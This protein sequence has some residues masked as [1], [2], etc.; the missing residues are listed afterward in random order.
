[1]SRSLRL[2]D[3]MARWPYPRRINPA[4]EEVSAESAA[5]LRSFHA[6]SAEAQVAFDK[7]KFGEWLSP[8]PVPPR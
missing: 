2:P 6:F 1:M 8:S 5:W 4:Y 7:C 3:T